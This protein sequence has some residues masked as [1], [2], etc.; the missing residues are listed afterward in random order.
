MQKLNT[1][2]PDLTEQKIADIAKIFPNTVTEKESP[3]G[4]ITK[5]VDFDLLRQELSKNIV[6]DGEERYRLDWP[7]KKAALLKAN[8]PINKTLRPVREDSVNFDTTENIYIEGDNFEALKILQESYLNK[9]KMIY[10]DPPY[11]TGK[12]LVYK[13]NFHQ[14]KEEFDEETGAVDEEGNKLFKENAKTNPRFHSDWLSMMYERLTIARDLLR[15]DGVIFI[16]IDDNEVHNLRKICDEIFG[17]DN[18]IGCFVWEKKKKGAFL[19]G[20]ITNV[21]EYIIC[22]SKD[23]TNFRGLIGETNTESTTYPIIKTTNSRSTRVIRAGI[24]S[25]YSKKNHEVKSGTRISVGNQEMILLSDLIIVDG[26]LINDVKVDSNWIYSQEL[27]DQY[28]KKNEL[29]ITQDLYFRR[30]VNEPRDKMIKD[31]LPRVGVSGASG[32]R[33]VYSDNLFDDGWGTNEDGN[34]E[35]HQLL[36]FQNLLDFPK[37][38]K[39]ITKLIHSLRD[40]NSICFDFFSGSATTAHAVMQLNAEDRGNR[41]FVLVQLPEET[42][43]DSEACKAGYKNICEIG[44][45]RIRRA[46]KKILEENKDK[47][48]IDKLDVGFRVYRVDSTNYADVTVHPTDIIQENLFSTVNNIKSDRTAEDLLTEV[49]LSLGLEL[50]LPITRKQIDYKEVFYVAEN[51]LVACFDQDITEK[52]IE[53]IASIQPLKAVFRDSSFKDDKDRINFENK[54]KGISP[55]TEISVI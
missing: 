42:K 5:V 52:L 10:I 38:S 50:S 53:E 6:E 26:K 2:T 21:K 49:I 13:D 16:S 36:G 12:D 27:L 31:L 22:Y 37:P 55:D 25:K 14:A 4:T 47:E 29:Y 11:N 43:E 51:S 35:L 30:I 45:E 17:E 39:L 34:A 15:K 40:K 23:L 9:I 54:F 48:G 20:S 1:Q 44:K 19:S 33:F 32:N 8:T 41:K 3:D 18:F 7:G 28:A 24:S 46:G